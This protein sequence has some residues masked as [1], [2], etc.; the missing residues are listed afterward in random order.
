MLP[1]QYSSNLQFKLIDSDLKCQ[2]NELG[3]YIVNLNNL[4]TQV[5]IFL[6]IKMILYIFFIFFSVKGAWSWMII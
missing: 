1:A 2:F 6:E 5:R 3:L 4:A